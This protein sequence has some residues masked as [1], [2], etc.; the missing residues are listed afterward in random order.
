MAR[1]RPGS[2]RYDTS[3]QIFVYVE[4]L[5]QKSRPVDQSAGLFSPD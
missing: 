3:F 5:G 1:M 2:Q 4:M